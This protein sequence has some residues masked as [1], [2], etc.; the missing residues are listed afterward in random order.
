MNTDRIADFK[1]RL[2]YFNQMQLIIDQGAKISLS[3]CHFTEILD[4]IIQS[5]EASRICCEYLQTRTDLI[6]SECPESIKK[7]IFQ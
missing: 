2:Y 4:N 6:C 7:K 1:N 3:S 5:N